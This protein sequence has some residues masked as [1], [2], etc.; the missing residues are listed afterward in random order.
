M[1]KS[2]ISREDRSRKEKAIMK[3][4]M[5]FPEIAFADN[6]D[7]LNH[8]TKKFSKPTDSLLLD[9]NNNNNNVSVDLPVGRNQFAPTM[10]NIRANNKKKGKSYRRN[11]SAGSLSPESTRL[12]AQYLQ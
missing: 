11:N 4:S 1:N 9:N 3:G 7:Q 6:N 12:K 8:T 5:T 10:I 2:Q